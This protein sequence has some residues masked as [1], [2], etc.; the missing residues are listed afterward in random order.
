VSKL[1]PT[2]PAEVKQDRLRRARIIRRGA[3]LLLTAFVVLGALG[4]FGIRTRVAS[5]AGGGYHLTVAYP[6]TDRPGE[7]IH[8][9]ITVTR[10][11]GFDAPIDI[12]ITQSYLDLLDLNDIE[13]APTA[14]HTNG[15]FVVWTFDPPAGNVL[16]VSVD[17]LIQLNT[18]F[19]SEADVA[20][21]EGGHPVVSVNYRTWVAP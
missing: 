16:R 12:G 11:G 3:L 20:V 4:F 7:P 8:W 19:G 21:L 17:A 6:H 15:P 13:P 2:A 14:T 9:V 18:H 10:S 1:P 5:S